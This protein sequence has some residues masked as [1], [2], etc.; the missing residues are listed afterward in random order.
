[1]YARRHAD[2]PRYS[3]GTGKVNALGAFA[4]AV[5]LAC[6]AVG[7]LWESGERFAHPGVIRYGD[8]LMVAFVG[9]AV[10][11]LSAF[12][13]RNEH[14]DHDHSHTAHHDLGH[15]HSAVHHDHVLAEGVHA[16]DTNLKAAYLHVLAD[17]L[18]SVLAIA[19][20]LVGRRWNLARADSAV[21]FLGAFVIL[22][23]AYGLVKTTSR[24]LLDADVPAEML[25][26]VRD[27]VQ[28]VPDTRVVDLHIW[29]LGPQRHAAIVSVV[30]DAAPDVYKKLLAEEPA[31]AHV[32]VEVNPR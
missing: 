16:H 17:A 8:A 5:L 19:A 25:Q 28:T 2:D 11:G 9:L 1:A 13:L 21:G 14:H 22:K 27:V 15:N 6:I 3:F 18:T 24:E 10:N 23:W 30:S 29:R 26:R 32:T 20:L 4:S 7:M 12:L 31:L